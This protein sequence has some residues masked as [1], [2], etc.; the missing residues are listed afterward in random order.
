MARLRFRLRTA[1]TTLVL[2]LVATASSSLAEAGPSRSVDVSRSPEVKAGAG[3]EV[4]AR[5]EPERE[6]QESKREQAAADVAK[7]VRIRIPSID[8]DAEIVGVGLDEDGAMETPDIGFAGWYTKGPKPGEKGPSVVVAH[9]DSKAGPDVFN[10]L[11]EL[12]PGAEIHI[13]RSDG[14][15]ATWLSESSEQTDK[16]EL[17]VGS[18][19][20]PTEEPVL[21]LVTCGGAF[22]RSIGHYT[23]NV[24]V[25]ASPHF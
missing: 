22:D 14:S 3:A 12:R 4:E 17:P 5:A 15:T 1:A 9:V 2:T 20:K 10:R 13:E 7:P 19:W 18:I 21:R 16:D 6:S 11:N 23:D 25:Y 24:I 8:V